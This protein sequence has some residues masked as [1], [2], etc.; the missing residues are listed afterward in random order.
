M[1]IFSG[2][3]NTI[4]LKCAEDRAN[5]LAD[6][7][8]KI[9]ARFKENLDVA[10]EMDVSGN[11]I[12]EYAE[13]KTKDLPKNLDDA[14]YLELINLNTLLQDFD[15]IRR[16]L[17]ENTEQGRAII[18]TLGVDISA[19]DPDSLAELITSYAEL[20]K[21]ITDTLKLFVQAYKDISTIITNLE[22]VK[23][24]FNKTTNNLNITNISDNSNG[25]D[26]VST[27]AD[28]IKQIK[29]HNKIVS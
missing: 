6:R 8:N 2:I 13:D 15:Y 20:N 16:T 19:S 3:M 28:I 4:D 12:I 26:I 22:K 7:M 10:D 14:S 24:G 29:E 27:T 5:K 21:S 25:L 11:D 18:K 23:S 9:T 17:R 1:E